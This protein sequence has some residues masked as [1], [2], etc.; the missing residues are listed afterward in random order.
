[1]VIQIL[2]NSAVETLILCLIVFL[3]LFMVLANT[4]GVRR[5]GVGQKNRSSCFFL[6]VGIWV[7][8]LQTSR[9]PLQRNLPG[10][11]PGALG[12]CVRRRD[13]L[14]QTALYTGRGP[15]SGDVKKV[16]QFVFWNR[17]WDFGL[18]STNFESASLA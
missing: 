3:M 12:P 18:T 4:I 14:A 8:L 2:I 6:D 15:A 13:K 11:G 7:S 5:L 10:L 1:M 9:V 17:C 16:D